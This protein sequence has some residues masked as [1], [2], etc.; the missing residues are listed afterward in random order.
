MAHPERDI[1]TVAFWDAQAPWQQSWLAHCCYHRDIIPL[2]LGQ[3]SPGWKVLDIGAGSGVLALPLQQQG[4]Q[5]TALEPS[6]GMRDLL[7]QAL[8]Q[9][10]SAH[11]SIDRRRWEEVSLSQL[12]GYHLILACNS[13]HVT[14]LG[15]TAALDR[16][17]RAAPQ[18]VCVISESR[19]VPETAFQPPGSYRLRWQQ[20]L[21]ADSSLAY[22]SLNE[23]WEYFQ[24]HWGRPPTPKEKATLKQ[25]LSYRQQHY[26]LLQRVPLGIW[27]WSKRGVH[28]SEEFKQR[29]FLP[30]KIPSSGLNP[31][32]AGPLR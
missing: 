11:L 32:Q 18:H 9:N 13:L 15:F 25:E 21:T 17:F 20:Y 5:V 12:R 23:V 29:A 10:P 2:V 19:F 16:I 1:S 7:R 26:W 24:H 4:C 3:T 14:S 30:D 31:A 22:H 28:K 6:R 27:W 8:R